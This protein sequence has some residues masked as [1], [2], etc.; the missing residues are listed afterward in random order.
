[1]NAVKNTLSENLNGLVLTAI[2]IAVGAMLLCI[3]MTSRI[4]RRSKILSAR[5]IV[6]QMAI[7]LRKLQLRIQKKFQRLL[8]R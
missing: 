8:R 6:M 3:V 7:F 2:F 1:M 5:L 4:L